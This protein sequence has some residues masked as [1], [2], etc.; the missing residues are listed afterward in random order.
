MTSPVQS[1]TPYDELEREA[2][3]IISGW[4][5]GFHTRSNNLHTPKKVIPITS[6]EILDQLREIKKLCNKTTIDRLFKLVTVH[7]RDFNNPHQT[8]LSQFAT[9]ILHLLYKE[10]TNRGGVAPY[11]SFLTI[12]FE[13]YQIAG[14]DDIYDGTNP[15]LLT[16]VK[17]TAKYIKEH[18][19]SE[20]AHAALFKKMFPGVPPTVEP[21]AAIMSLYGVGGTHQTNRGDKY[22]YIGRDGYRHLA[23]TDYLPTDYL[24]GKPMLAIFGDRTNEC[25]YSRDFSQTDTWNTTNLDFGYN[26]NLPSINKIDNL[27]GA[28]L[29]RESVD[30][31]STEH[32]LSYLHTPVE[33]NKITNISFDIK[34][35]KCKYLCIRVLHKIFGVSKMSILNFENNTVSV[36][37]LN[38]IMSVRM[39][40]IAEGYFHIEYSIIHS[41]AGEIEIQHIPYHQSIG[42]L[43]YAGLGEDV[44]IIDNYQCE[45]GDIIGCSPFIYTEGETKTRHGIRLT[46]P[47][48][49]WYNS[50]EGG[51][52]FEFINPCTLN[53][54]IERTLY[55]FR[56]ETEPGMTGNYGTNNIFFVRIYD[57]E[58]VEVFDYPL[59]ATNR[60]KIQMS[61]SYDRVNFLMGITGNTGKKVSTILT[62]KSNIQYL[63]IGHQNGTKPFDGYFASYVYYRETLSEDNITFL[64]GE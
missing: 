26:Q 28:T 57:E 60:K 19:D 18:D 64:V 32:I 17:L 51:F 43:K 46:I 48:L 42:A 3:A 39:I 30:I 54:N 59:L 45:Y 22:T 29:F 11:D 6:Q 12:L 47:T 24:F 58:N 9:D 27:K 21:A 7:A 10:Y 53:T 2:T 49:D 63:D 37:E 25:K 38:N 41:L 44:C 8:D 1:E 50:E 62:K 16:T 4:D 34:P 20:T 13:D 52:A 14:L 61:F 5:G 15:K 40:K 36:T 55:N 23:A 56:D 31:L 35:I 33:A